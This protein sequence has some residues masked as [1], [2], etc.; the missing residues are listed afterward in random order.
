MKRFKSKENIVVSGK[1]VFM[2]ENDID[3]ELNVFDDLWPLVE[4][5][6]IKYKTLGAESHA[7]PHCHKGE[8]IG[9]MVE[10]I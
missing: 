6:G 8:I 2:V 3:R 1:K 7:I 5:D 9:I 10:I 4:I